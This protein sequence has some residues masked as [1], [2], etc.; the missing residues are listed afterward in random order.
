MTWV[1]HVAWMWEMQILYEIL[2]GKP[3]DKIPI[4]RSKLWRQD[5]IKLNLKDKEG[6]DWIGFIWLTTEFGGDLLGAV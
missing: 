5:N 1:G 4:I 3:E 6:E 2:D